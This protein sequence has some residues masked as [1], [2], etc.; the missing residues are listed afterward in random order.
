MQK[1]WNVLFLCNGNSARGVMAESILNGRKDARFHGYSAGSFPKELV[2]PEAVR[3]LDLVGLPTEGLRPKSW[4]EF[5]QPGAPIMDFVFTLSD[6]ATGE[7]CPI[8]P[9]QPITAH[10]G[11]PDPS[12]VDGSPARV[13]VAFAEAFRLLDQRVS[14]FVSLP[15]TTLDRMALTR[16][17]REIGTIGSDT[18]TDKAS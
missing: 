5:A 14:L 11:I 18:I 17:V 6:Q 13:G 16:R 3:L 7:I 2:R 10:W 12:A 4:E 15:F 9:G 1:I 8:W